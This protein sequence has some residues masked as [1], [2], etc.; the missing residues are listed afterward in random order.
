[1]A[2]RLDKFTKPFRDSRIPFLLT[3]VVTDG[4]GEMVDV[5]C[6]FLNGPAAALLGL[7]EKELYRQRFTHIFPAA[8]LET[9]EPL[10]E[11]AF[12]G[13]AASFPFTTAL[14]QKITVTCYQPRYGMAACFL[15]PVREEAP[16][17]H[18]RF[19]A[20]NLP[21]VILSL[22]LSRAGCRCLSFTQGL[23][24]LT[25]RSRR[26]LL[27][28]CADFTALAEPEDR[29]ELLQI[30]LDAARENRRTTHRFHLSRQDGEPAW[31][32][33]RA[34]VAARREGTV[35]FYAVLL[36]ARQDRR[37]QTRLEETQTRLNDALAELN[38]FY[39][40][41]PAPLCLFRREAAGEAPR[42][43]RLSRELSGLLGCP[44]PELERRLAEDPLWR[45]MPADREALLSAAAESRAAGRPLRHVCRLQ[46][47][48]GGVLWAALDVVWHGLESGAE[49][50]YSGCLDITKE[51]ELSR[52]VQ[53]RA[54]L[55]E[56]MLDQARMMSFDYDPVEDVARSWRH[57]GSS[58]RVP[59]VREHYLSHMDH[60]PAIHPDDRKRRSA[61]IRR[62]LSR[63]GMETLEYRANYDGQGWRWCHISWVSVM[64][65]TGSV[66][67]L[68]GRAED[69]T[70]RKMSALRFETLAAGQKKLPPGALAVIRLDL[71]ADRIT[72][73]K[74]SSR[75]LSGVLFGN[76]ADA[77][78][79]HLRDN[80]PGEA[81]R[82]AFDEKFRRQ[83]L[84][85]APQSGAVK[86]ELEHRFSLGEG[87]TVW[88]RTTA[89][90]AVNPETLAFTAFCTVLNIDAQRQRDAL[91]EALTRRDYDFVLTVNADTGLC[92]V[93]GEG[94]PS[95]PLSYRSAAARYLDTQTPSRKRSAFRQAAR[96]ETVLA[97]LETEEVY[98]YVGSL[99]VEASREKRM[100]W[101]WL[102]REGR[103]LLVTL[104]SVGEDGR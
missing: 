104:E 25:G 49:L 92:R 67:R 86:V 80:I 1:M 73:A 34:E 75:Y 28:R 6:L 42:P 87:G 4:Q 62:L 47:K 29:P 79:R 12:S 13:S 99:D 10:R 5:V 41:L 52:E 44:L 30:L 3:E 103:V 50:I 71:T 37:I 70:R 97:H 27:D 55:C 21:G 81:Q 88:V 48:G 64:D 15:E 23:C 72:D 77:C 83:A 7:P 66:C 89:E 61:M 74:T 51:R 11:V 76:T 85:E 65:G 84:L 98:E 53:F 26:E 24:A 102:D 18:A 38:L 82:Q 8:A 100:R 46:A 101:S 68:L 54:Q 36:D 58:H 19:L 63:P 2:K 39:D 22:E 35:S 59:N 94:A 56:L 90:I 45:V 17:A 95:E 96:L 33:L 60:D 93:Y 57:D 14:N 31:V 20:E 69:I 32:E 43:V 78:L 91:P 9:L 40:E 16:P